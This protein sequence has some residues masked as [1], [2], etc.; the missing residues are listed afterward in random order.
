MQGA[1]RTEGRGFGILGGPEA[2][3]HVMIIMYQC[4][5]G[6]KKIRAEPAEITRDISD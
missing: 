6:R 5:D 1:G 2:G 3:R 4:R